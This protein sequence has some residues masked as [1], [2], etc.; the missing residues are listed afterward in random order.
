MK[1]KVKV[2]KD[3]RQEVIF[4]EET[5]ITGKKRTRTVVEPLDDGNG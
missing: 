2:K 4:H 5:R 3:Q 1:P